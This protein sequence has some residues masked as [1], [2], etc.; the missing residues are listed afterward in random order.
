MMRIEMEGSTSG[1]RQRG[2]AAEGR[3]RRVAGAL[4]G[5]AVLLC[6]C[7]KKTADPAAEAPPGGSAVVAVGDPSLVHVDDTGK[8]PLV[9]AVEHQ[10]PSTLHVTGSVNPDI[11]REIPVVALANGR[12]VATHV[13]LGDYVHKGQL[14]MEVQSTDIANAFNQYLKAV[15]DERLARTVLDRDQLLYAKGAIAKSQL[16]IAQDA[17][18]DALADLRAAEQQ[19]HILGVDKN[20][21]GET[22]KVL[23]PASGF[24]IQ[25]NVTQASTAGVGL[26]GSPNAFVIADLSHV[27]ILCDVYENDLATVHVGQSADIRLNAY[28]DRLLTGTI[29]DVGALLDPTLRTGKVRIQVANPQYIMRV[30]MFATATFHGKKPETHAE[31]PST[32]ILHLHDRDWVYVPAHGAGNAQY[33]RIAVVGGEMLPGGMQEVSSGLAAGQQVVRNALELQNTAA[34]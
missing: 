6:G 12:V 25:Q 19:L 28:P 20:H 30:G 5:A 15:N 10:A 17:E 16:D 7:G 27:W 13:R 2:I 3:R 32:A 29:G 31:V 4:L 26:S 24:I 22:V 34:Q 8:F 14:V 9:S 1:Q 11:S 33:Q 23:A 18:D 21:P